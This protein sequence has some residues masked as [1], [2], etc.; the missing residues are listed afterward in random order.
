MLLLDGSLS[1][2][3]HC[4]KTVCKHAYAVNCQLIFL[5]FH[6]A[7]SFAK[8]RICLVVLFCLSVLFCFLFV[9]LYFNQWI[10][11]YTLDTLWTWTANSRHKVIVG[12]YDTW[13]ISLIITSAPVKATHSWASVESIAIRGC[14]NFLRITTGNFDNHKFANLCSKVYFRKIDISEHTYFKACCSPNFLECEKSEISN[15]ISHFLKKK[16]QNK[17][18]R[19]IWNYWYFCF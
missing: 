16:C 6:Y 15:V 10:P 14:K 12:K 13:T 2:S 5:I 11:Q 19:W 17:K 3:L 9:G 18:N 8:E 1:T 7:E 4:C